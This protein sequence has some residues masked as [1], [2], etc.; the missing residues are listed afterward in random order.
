MVANKSW[1]PGSLGTTS[2]IPVYAHDGPLTLSSPPS[3]ADTPY[4]D[5]RERTA[6][7]E[8]N[9]NNSG[10]SASSADADDDVRS[11]FE[12]LFCTFYVGIG[13]SCRDVKRNESHCFHNEATDLFHC[14]FV[15]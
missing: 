10:F 5:R 11:T 1:I 14:P 15:A 3:F 8:D 2:L 12:N 9:V 4:I 7:V 13:A 6:A